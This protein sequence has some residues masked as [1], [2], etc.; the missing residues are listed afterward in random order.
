MAKK[1]KTVVADAY[2]LDIRRGL[3][4]PFEFSLVLQADGSE[5]ALRVDTMDE[6][7]ALIQ[8]LLR[9]LADLWPARDVQ[10]VVEG[11]EIVDVPA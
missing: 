10:V 7:T 2:K 3:G 11:N 9:Q 1:K 5:F 8:K 6:S 4:A